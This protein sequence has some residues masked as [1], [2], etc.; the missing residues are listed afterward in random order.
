MQYNPLDI[1]LCGMVP[2]GCRNFAETRSIIQFCNIIRAMS[3]C[4]V[5]LRN[6]SWI[7]AENHWE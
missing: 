2:G 3:Q 4:L 1:V 7:D 6:W 5:A